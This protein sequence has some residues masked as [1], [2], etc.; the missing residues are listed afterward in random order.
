MATFPTGTM[1]GAG[2]NLDGFINEV[3]SAKILNFA[4]EKKHFSTFFT[5]RSDELA[6]GGDTVKT[7]SMSEMS[8]ASKSSATAVTMNAVTDANVDLVVNTWKEV[9]FAIEDGT[10]ALFLKSRYTQTN[11]AKNAGYTAG[12]TLED[13]IAALFGTFTDSVGAS[14]SVILDSDIRK[15]IGIAEANTKEEVTDGNFA[16]F[17]DTKV[18]WNQI[19]GITTYQLKINASNDPVTQR[20]VTKLYGVTVMLSNRIPYVSSTTGRY[21]ALAH[22]DAIHYAISPL[23]GQGPAMVRVQSNYVPQYLS[24]VT[25]ADIQFGVKLMRATY[26]VNILTSAS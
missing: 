24:T 17:F 1:T 20:P 14:T 4:Q 25:T 7:G 22:K 23:P 13:A 10:V 11:Y 2:G 5:D 12:N 21:N 19:A 6:G 9:S 8:A 15:A 18:W 26:G 3:W 16:F